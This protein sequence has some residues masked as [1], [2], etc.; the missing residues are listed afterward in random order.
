[1]VEG[2]GGDNG[3]GAE[4]EQDGAWGSEEDGDRGYAPVLVPVFR[5]D[6][7]EEGQGEVG[8]GGR[9]RLLCVPDAAKG[10]GEWGVDGVG[11]RGSQLA[12]E[13]L[14]CWVCMLRA[15]AWGLN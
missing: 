4:A 7:E 14:D 15:Q 3:G 5:D 11:V 8:R 10:G 2:D 12:R 6:S 1:M 13:G 9:E